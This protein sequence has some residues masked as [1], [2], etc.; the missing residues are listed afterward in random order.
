MKKDKT[1]GGKVLRIMTGDITA[2]DTDAIV[3]A[4]NN[5]LQHGGGVALAISRK[6]GP[7][8]QQESNR[9]GHCP[10][11]G[12]VLTGGGKLKAKYVIHTV[13]PRMGEGDEDDKL[14]SATLSCL[15]LADG[16][17]MTSLTFPA[18]SAGI[19][20]FPMDRCAKIMLGEAARY[21]KGD[22]KIALVVFCLFDERACQ[23]FE[24]AF[25]NLA[26]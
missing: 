13:G 4:A 23:I 2:S 20:G 26:D 19:Y 1:I 17:G 16:K 11:G 12:A 6:G 24:K 18:V 25:D 3:N 21:L 10:T 22:S 8:I 9:I 15:K 5:R 7:A 14:R